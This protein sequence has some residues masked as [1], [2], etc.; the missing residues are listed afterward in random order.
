DAL[1]VSY[2]ALA[3]TESIKFPET[4]GDLVGLIIM[5]FKTSIIEITGEKDKDNHLSP[6]TARLKLNPDIT[7]QFSAFLGKEAV[8]VDNVMLKMKDGGDWENLI[9]WVN[10]YHDYNKALEE[11]NENMSDDDI[12]KFERA[13]RDIIRAEMLTQTSTVLLDESNAPKVKIIPGYH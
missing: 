10:L 1:S 6:K 2:Y 4:K 7:V 8:D 13:T 3:G 5:L 12:E 11:Q 9:C